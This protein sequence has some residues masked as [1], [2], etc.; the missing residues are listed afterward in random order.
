MFLSVW[1]SSTL[2]SSSGSQPA[3]PRAKLALHPLQ[4]AERVLQ[5]P[6]HR[7]QTPQGGLLTP[8]KEEREDEVEE[9]AHRGTQ[10]QVSSISAIL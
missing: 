10:K 8:C 9:E 7:C 6:E 1:H 2:V 5:E 4:V 3:Q